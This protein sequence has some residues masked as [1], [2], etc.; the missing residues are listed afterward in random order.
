VPGCVVPL[1]VLP[2]FFTAVFIFYICFALFAVFNV[3][4]GV[5]CEN[6]IE[7]AQADRGL[8]VQ[9]HMEMRKQYEL[10]ARRL[11]KEI[12]SDESNSIT[13]DEFESHW[14]TEEAAA[15]FMTLDIEAEQAWELFRLL[16]TDTGGCIDI[17]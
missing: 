14:N 8:A 3:I 12:D 13:L 5:F 11:F 16:D 17:E 1:A 7:G 6:A 15:F 2:G 9:K 10:A 4:I